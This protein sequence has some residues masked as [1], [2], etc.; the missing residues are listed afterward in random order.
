[1]FVIVVVFGGRYLSRDMIACNAM[2]PSSRDPRGA[3]NIRYLSSERGHMYTWYACVASEPILS[4]F[5]FKNLKLAT[6][7]SKN[8]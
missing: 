1:M 2:E 5:K 7:G 3:G 6:H 4:R 8:G